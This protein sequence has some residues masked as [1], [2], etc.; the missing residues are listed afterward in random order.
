MTGIAAHCLTA[1]Y[2]A[3]ALPEKTWPAGKR[4]GELLPMPLAGMD[5]GRV[6]GWLDESPPPSIIRTALNWRS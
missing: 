5:H 3:T 1:I 2:D 6:G 4:R